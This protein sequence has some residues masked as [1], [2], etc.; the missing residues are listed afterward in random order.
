MATRTGASSI[1]QH[2]RAICRIV[3]IYG[4]QGLFAYTG[5]AQLRDAVNLLVVACQAYEALDNIPGQIDRQAPY[6][7]EDEAGS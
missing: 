6:G 4:V 3:G 2:T 7:A 5:S 1:L